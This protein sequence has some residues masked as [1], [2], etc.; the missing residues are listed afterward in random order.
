MQTKHN[1][2]DHTC[3]ICREVFAQRDTLLS[4]ISTHI[5]D[6]TV[7]SDITKHEITLETEKTK[8]I[9]EEKKLS[10]KISESGDSDIIHC[11]EQEGSLSSTAQ[12]N[13]ASEENNNTPKDPISSDLCLLRFENEEKLNFHVNTV[14]LLKRDKLCSKCG[15][16]H[17]FKS[18]LLRHIITC[19]GQTHFV[20]KSCREE[21]DSEKDYVTHVNQHKKKVS[22][23]QQH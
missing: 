8:R 17:F 3:V 20:C 18:D 16:T 1:Q 6:Q 11:A 7:E 22:H 10:R 23:L 21:F 19:N 15:K 2:N 14:H 9:V 12:E 5:V 13:F 4:H